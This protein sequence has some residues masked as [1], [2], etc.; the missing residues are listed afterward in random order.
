MTK[1]IPRSHCVKC[2]KDRSTS[3]CLGCLNDFCY[4]HLA[5]HR[6][7]LSRQLDHIE[8]NRDVFKQNFNEEIKHPEKYYLLKQIDK[9][10]KDSIKII[11]QTAIEC[12]KI[13]MQ[14]REQY[15]DQIELNLNKLTEK[16]RKI[17]Q[18]SDFNEI[19][20]SHFK[21][22]FHKLQKQFQ[23]SPNVYI[24]QNSTA[25]INKISIVAAAGKYI[26]ALNINN[27]TIWNQYGTTIADE[28]QLHNP[29]GICVDDDNQIVYIADCDNHRIVECKYGVIN[30]ETVAGGN[31]EGNRMDQLNYPTDVILDKKSNSLIICDYRNSRV[32]RCSRENNINQDII[33]SNI[34]CWGLTMDNNGDIYVSDWKNNEVKRWKQGEINGTIVAGG[35]GEGDHDNQL[36]FPT[37]IFVDLNYSIY[38]SDSNNHRVMKWLKDAKQGIVVAGGYGQ[39]NCFRQLSYPR[40]IIVDHLGKIYIADSGNNR[41]MRWCKEDEEGSIIVGGNGKGKQLNQFTSLNGISFD[42]QGNL[43]VVD[44][45]NH[46]VQK[47]Q[48]EIN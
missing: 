34:N 16:L 48:I 15:L 6:D 47:F 25:L 35:N 26:P 44:K 5:Y 45:D 30:G 18:K 40:G 19:D 11:Q 12:K 43:Y 36:H 9:W 37:Y 22:K 21:N 41:V 20:L 38:I 42:R 4:N 23:L 24:H 1:E 32:I 10:E 46:R 14:Y 7:E 2:G 17:R 27:D 29:Y 39:G 28:F 3:T 33:I 13:L 8:L 31:G